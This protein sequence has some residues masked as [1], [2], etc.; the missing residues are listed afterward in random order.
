LVD[1]ADRERAIVGDK[2]YPFVESIDYQ[3]FLE[4]GG[5]PELWQDT[6]N[7]NDDP[8]TTFVVRYPA[9]RNAPSIPSNVL[10]KSIELESGKYA[11]YQVKRYVDVKRRDSWLWN[12]VGNGNSYPSIYQGGELIRPGCGH[13]W[14]DEGMGCLNVDSHAGGM[15]KVKIISNKCMRPQCPVDYEFWAAREAGRIEDRFRRVPKL[16]G[17]R[18]NPEGRSKIGVPIHLVISVPECDS[19]MMDAVTL[20]VKRGR[21]RRAGNS[22]AGY[23]AELVK[24]VQ[25]KKL[26]RKVVQIAK[27]VGFLGGCMIFHPFAN[28]EMKDEDTEGVTISYDPASG[29]FDYKEL[30]KFMDRVNY[31]KAAPGEA[32][33]ESRVWFIRPH[34]HLIGYG[35]IENVGQVHEDTGYVVKNLGVRDSVFMTALYQLSHAGYREGQHTVS[36]IGVMSNRTYKKLDPTEELPLAPAKCPECGDELKAV[37]WVGEGLSPLSDKTEEGMYMVDPAGWEYIPDVWV[38]NMYHP[39][40]G[41]Y[42]SGLRSRGVH[43]TED[44]KDLRERMRLVVA[45]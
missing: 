42:K 16:N 36:W 23:Q 24:V 28:D 34:F 8:Y 30:K 5:T 44:E 3:G 35:W 7:C 40:G 17:D 25:F 11:Q 45:K 10:E 33:K 1:L 38:D 18:F 27:K 2:L 14:L 6:I 22:D 31:R 19:G 20:E 41:Y 26:K 39:D 15:A 43:P 4:A 12:L 29:E 21:G 9:S 13:L 37:K 32:P